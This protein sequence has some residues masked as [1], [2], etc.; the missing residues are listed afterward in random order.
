MTMVDPGSLPPLEVAAQRAQS[1]E[2]RALRDGGHLDSRRSVPM[3]ED[4]MGVLSLSLEAGCHRIEIFG[5]D[6]RRTRRSKRLDIDAELRDDDGDILARDRTEA[7]DARI[8]TC[9]GEATGTTLVMAGAEP[10]TD[11]MVTHALWPI[12]D[13]LP[14]VWEGQARARMAQALL[15]HRA[16]VPDS[17]PVFLTQGTAGSTAVPLALQPGACYLAAAAIAQGSPRGLGLRVRVSGR[18]YADDRGVGGVGAVVA[19]CTGASERAVATVDARG[20]ALAWGLVIY[21]MH[22]LPSTEGTP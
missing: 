22:T 21:Q 6:R 20:A 9:L 2:Q 15:A 16:R 3:G 1:A 18:D 4:G 13:R 5:E 17:L 10:A 14:W 8:E 12:P 7:P 11:A 19:F